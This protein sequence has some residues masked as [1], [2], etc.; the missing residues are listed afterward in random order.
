MR[1]CLYTADCGTKTY[2]SNSGL[3]DLK[4]R[5]RDFCDRRFFGI[6]SESEPE[7]I[8]WVRIDVC[9]DHSGTASTEKI[10]F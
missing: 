5:I 7:R 2:E 10:R 8:D 6:T 4:F 3:L 9:C 1:S